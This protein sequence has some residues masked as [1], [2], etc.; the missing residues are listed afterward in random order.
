MLC[1]DDNSLDQASF[2]TVTRNAFNAAPLLLISG[3]EDIAGT[4][5][6]RRKGLDLAFDFSEIDLCH[7][8]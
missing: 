4:T 8:R 6:L 2:R 1:N 7:G 5:C 3:D